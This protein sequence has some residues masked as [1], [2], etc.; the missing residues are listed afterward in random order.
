[1]ACLSA[2][3]ATL[4]LPGI[5]GFI[6]TIGM[7][8]D[9]NVIIFERVKEELASGRPF[10]AAVKAGFS[11]ATV[12][13][14]DANITTLL[15][16]GVLFWLGTGVIKGFAITLTVGI[17]VSMVTALVVMQLLLVGLANRFGSH[18]GWFFGK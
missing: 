9:A 3:N 17:L 16:A 5:A 4:T 14:L 10:L 8:V 13:I 1:M 11:Q 7:A 6:L 18:S 12:T 15:A 2:L